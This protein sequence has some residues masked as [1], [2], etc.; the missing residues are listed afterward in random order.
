LNNTMIKPNR[1]VLFCLV[2]LAFLAPLK[3]GTAVVLQFLVPLPHG[4]WEWFFFSWPNQLATMFVFGTLIWIVADRH[5]MR[6]CVDPLFALPILWLATQV[7]ATPGTVCRQLTG[8]T[9][10]FFAACVLVFYAAA[11]YTRDGAAANRIFA[12]LAFATVI[13]VVIALSQ[14]F[15]GLEETRNFAA[16]LPNAASLPADLKGKLT[17]TRVFGT[18]G[19]PNALAGYL[20][21]AFGPVLGWIWVRGRG[22]DARVKWATLV[23]ASGLMLWCLVLT[24]SRGGLAAMVAAAVAGVACMTGTVT[25]RVL[26]ATTA[27][28]VVVIAVFLAT[29]KRGFSS[30]VARQEYWQGAISIAQ[31]HPWLGTGPGTFGSVYLKYKTGVN[32]EAQLA[33]NNYLQMWS[34]SGAM[35]FVVFTVMWLLA[36]T[37]AFRLARQRVGDVA[38]VAICASLTGWA[39]HGLVD[40]DLYVPGIAL[41]V[42]LLLG[43]LQG[44]KELPQIAVAR[45]YSHRRRLLGLVG[46]L[47]VVVVF[48]TQ[49]RA[50]L[51][52]T[53]F[54]KAQEL[55]TQGWLAQAQGA[56]EKAV[57][58]MPYNSRFL[59]EAGDIAMARHSYA[60]AADRY[61]KAAAEDPY[62]SAYHERIAMAEMAANGV[63][64]LALKELQLAAELNPTKRE[65]RQA[66][67]EAEERVR[68]RA[69]GLLESPPIKE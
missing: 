30:F 61:A 51:A 60:E 15:G 5:R 41:P 67:F 43:I 63:T 37:D 53:W 68:Q 12:A 38:A 49:W 34:D 33:H 28:A 26:W 69:H 21:V 7:L 18:L 50:M 10:V 47:T 46:A 57:F 32:E 25:R 62:R 59:A 35:A 66:L 48:W 52:G 9:L 19:N 16:Q 65:Y 20:V 39:V 8:D 31:E 24:G 2:V 64:P 36:T 45:S 1:W 56:A 17:S 11:W 22:W 27:V 4:I 44:L 29:Q 3:F 58:Y 54:D 55:A 42:F 6:A 40:C 14:A 13:V 23:L